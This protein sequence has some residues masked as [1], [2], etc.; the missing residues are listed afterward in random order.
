MPAIQVT[1][2]G[3]PC[4]YCDRKIAPTTSPTIWWPGNDVI[5]ERLQLAFD[6]VQIGAAHAASAD[7]QQDLAGRGRGNRNIAD[8]ERAGR[9]ARRDA[10][11]TA[12]FILN[13]AF[14]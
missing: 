9:D 7:A 3:C 11:K 5:A 4:E 12:A 1:P 14:S 6:D 8:F 13:R 10:V 2:T